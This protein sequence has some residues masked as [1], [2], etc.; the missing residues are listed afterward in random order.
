[1]CVRVCKY[2]NIMR[3]YGIWSMYACVTMSLYIYNM[4]KFCAYSWRAQD[5]AAKTV[6]LLERDGEGKRDRK[7]ER[8]GERERSL[9]HPLGIHIYIYLIYD[10]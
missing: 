8:E 9:H 3:V 1:M 6:I 7:R 4:L 2:I 10:C 5:R